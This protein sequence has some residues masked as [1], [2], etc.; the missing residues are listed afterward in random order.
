MR[1][2]SDEALVQAGFGQSVR[3]R[4]ERALTLASVLYRSPSD[5]NDRRAARD[6]GLPR[7]R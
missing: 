1:A 2:R 6:A 7:P 4:R 3:T 5:R